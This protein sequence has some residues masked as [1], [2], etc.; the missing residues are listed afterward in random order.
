[1]TGE[2]P[3]KV[4]LAT[5]GTPGEYDYAVLRVFTRKADAD[6][7]E[8]AADVEEF[9]L[10]TGP[11]EARDFHVLRWDGQ[12]DHDPLYTA[13][14]RDPDDRAVSGGT[15]SVGAW[16]HAEAYAAFSKARADYDALRQ[17]MADERLAGLDRVDVKVWYEHGHWAV[18]TT[19]IHGTGDHFQVPRRRIAEQAGLS[20]DESLHGRWFTVETLTWLTADGFKVLPPV[21]GKAFSARRELG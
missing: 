1:M 13:E 16:S 6:R 20:A 19:P 21:R 2:T 4:Y 5:R 8:L 12:L 9:D 11:V 10:T 18:L 15:I 3:T 7:Y 14:R 17:Q